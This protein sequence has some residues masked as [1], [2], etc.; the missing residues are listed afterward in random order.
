[1]VI[2]L[3]VCFT[4]Y[5]ISFAKP[6]TTDTQNSCDFCRK[7]GLLNRFKFNHIK[8][9]TVGEQVHYGKAD[10]QVRDRQQVKTQNRFE[11][12]KS[13]DWTQSGRIVRVQ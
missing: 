10:W 13:R 12:G 7:Q 9:V 4:F 3:T 1:M 5:A 6:L 11:A 2:T 8:G